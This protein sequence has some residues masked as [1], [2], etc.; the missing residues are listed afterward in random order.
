MV[1]RGRLVPER[2]AR[3]GGGVLPQLHRDVATTR[4]VVVI[5]PRTASEASYADDHGRGQNKGFAGS[6]E[7]HLS[8]PKVTECFRN[9]TL[10][11][12]SVTGD[13]KISAM[14]DRWLY[15]AASDR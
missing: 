14:N 2:L 5:S 3:P 9:V 11:V 13:V 10:K 12:R 15:I 1:I 6:H 4:P 8:D 7:N